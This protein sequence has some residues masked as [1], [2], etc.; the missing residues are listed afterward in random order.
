MAVSIGYLTSIRRLTAKLFI[1]CGGD[2]EIRTPVLLT[3]FILKRCS[4]SSLVGEIG[5]HP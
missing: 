4:I 3:Y 1:A 5:Y 2:A